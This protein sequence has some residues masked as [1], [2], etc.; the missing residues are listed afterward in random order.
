M[1]YF[2]PLTCHKM[3]PLHESDCGVCFLVPTLLF[4]AEKPPESPSL[5]CS[6]CVWSFKFWLVN[7]LLFHSW[8]CLWQKNHLSHLRCHVLS[9]CDL[10]SFV[11][12]MNCYYTG[13]TCL[14]S[15]YVVLLD[16]F[17]VSVGSRVDITLFTVVWSSCSLF[18]W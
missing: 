16:V 1:G 12:S 5:S 10:L 15:F 4:M 14:V 6:F 11:L 17:H 18:K 7:N 13:Y 2:P 9:V 8:H 3:N